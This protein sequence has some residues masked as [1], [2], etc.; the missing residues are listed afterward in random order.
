MALL[1]EL[2]EREDQRHEWINR[3]GRR[4]LSRTRV[5]WQHFAMP[6]RWNRRNGCHS[7]L[8]SSWQGRKDNL[9]EAMFCQ[10]MQTC[11]NE[12]ETIRPVYISLRLRKPYKLATQ[13]H[14]GPPAKP[15]GRHD[16]LHVESLPFWSNDVFACAPGTTMGQGSLLNCGFGRFPFFCG[17]DR[18]FCRFRF[19]GGNELNW[20]E[21]DCLT[22]LNPSKEYDVTPEA[23]FE[24]FWPAAVERV[25]HRW[26]FGS[27][28][29]RKVF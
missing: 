29:I 26:W 27:K 28:S 20:F 16:G 8:K 13:T 11:H 25:F 2:Q 7:D 19:W 1:N 21:I 10:E 22:I 14:R 17:F 15:S 24:I 4:C 6:S 5:Y 9:H 3:G 12:Y 23:G 18:F